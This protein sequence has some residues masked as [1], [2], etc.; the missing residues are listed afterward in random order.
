MVSMGEDRLQ[1]LGRR[2]RDIFGIHTATPTKCPVCHELKDVFERCMVEERVVWI[3]SECMDQAIEQ[4][5]KEI[6]K[7]EAEHFGDSDY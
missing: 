4:L 1:H 6:E 7:Y 3:C 2:K 5:E